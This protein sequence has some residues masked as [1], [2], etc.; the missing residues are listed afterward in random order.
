MNLLNRKKTAKAACD[1]SP[2]P[3]APPLSRERGHRGAK[4]VSALLPS[5]ALR[6]CLALAL[7][8]PSLA[9]A[10]IP[11][12]GLVA[13]Y[14]F[15][16]N[17]NDESGNANHGTVYDA[18]LVP[19]RFGNANSAY[20]FDGVDDYFNSGINNAWEDFTIGVFAKV[21]TSVPFADVWGFR[22]AE[23]D[24]LGLDLIEGGVKFSIYF[25]DGGFISG[26]S[27]DAPDR[28]Q[29]HYTNPLTNPPFPICLMASSFFQPVF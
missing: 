24:G 15:N 26:T 9:L 21:T 5:A 22:N 10:Q 1:H 18:T 3:S 19:D 8:V 27:F 12:A 4:G 17:A 29:W 28:N 23:A 14:P 11:T 2:P 16:G 6:A 20:S 7:W 13:H 25:E